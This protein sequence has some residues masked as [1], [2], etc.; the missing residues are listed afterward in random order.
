MSKSRAPSTNKSSWGRHQS[1]IERL[2]VEE[3]RSI[4]GP[5]GVMS[6]M[7]RNYGFHANKSQY[8]YRISKWGKRKNI[9][10]QQWCT[11][12][13][14]LAQRSAEGKETEVRFQ[15]NLISPERVARE[16]ARYA[17]STANQMLP[18]RPPSDQYVQEANVWSGHES[19]ELGDVTVATPFVPTEPEILPYDFTFMDVELYASTLQHEWPPPIVAA[20]NVSMLYSM[21]WMHPMCFPVRLEY[22]PFH[23]LPSL[24]WKMV[25]QLSSQS[26]LI[27]P[28]TVRSDNMFYAPTTALENFFDGSR[29]IAEFSRV[30]VTILN[31]LD[32]AS[33]FNIS[34]VH[35]WL[36]SLPLPTLR[37]F[38]KALSPPLQD[39]LRQQVFKAAMEREDEITVQAMLE[40]GYDVHE[41]IFVGAMSVHDTVSPLHRALELRQFSLAKTIV[42]HLSQIEC[43]LGLQD[44]LQNIVN[45]SDLQRFDLPSL[46]AFGRKKWADLMQIPLAKGAN[47]TVGCFH[48]ATCATLDLLFSRG[49]TLALL[50]EGLVKWALDDLDYH[51][52]SYLN[53]LN[54]A[55]RRT[56]RIVTYLLGSGFKNVD[57]STPE[58]RVALSAAM[59]L[60]L[61][62]DRQEF[63]AVELIHLAGLQLQPP[64]ASKTYTDTMKFAIDESCA[65]GDWSHVRRMIDEP[66]DPPSPLPPDT[67]DDLYRRVISADTR[68]GFDA[69]IAEEGDWR[70]YSSSILQY[71]CNKALRFE[72]DDVVVA[73]ILTR[74]RFSRTEFASVLHHL[75]AYGQTLAVGMLITLDEQFAGAVGK[76]GYHR[77]FSMLENLL[78]R[79]HTASDYDDHLPRFGRLDAP[80]RLQLVLRAL[81]YHAIHTN[82]RDMMEWLMKNG[83]ETN[84]LRFLGSSTPEPRLLIASSNF[85]GVLA[86]PADFDDYTF[87][88]LLAI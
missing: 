81:S 55:M 66:G 27:K 22:Q 50:E 72:R 70:Q 63:W 52:R 65:T 77:N 3:R 64:L 62:V 12:A 6:Y 46:G 57:K 8:E 87:P 45:G 1:T 83:L 86:H 76:P 28:S 48:L 25:S 36:G 4:D 88:S 9:K 54:F 13:R 23:W 14:I 34:R 75:L 69:A 5:E 20:G 82:D 59:E 37:R 73:V 21:A 24:D 32:K 39:V 41:K 33:D 49:N 15:G 61:D 29:A 68:V 67:H 53:R 56:K 78:Y 10:K 47:A 51:R 30:I 58:L 40:L 42:T 74:P 7:E 44:L 17:N 60:A 43:E 2:Y 18:A 38:F 31:N 79:S 11:V 84:A 35:G 85:S 71:V 19:Q 16:L 26:D 80:S